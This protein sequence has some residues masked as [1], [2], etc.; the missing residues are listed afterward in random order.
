MTAAEARHSS[1]DRFGV[2]PTGEGRALAITVPVPRWAVARSRV[3]PRE[4]LGCAYFSFST[5]VDW[6]E[7][8]LEVVAR[9]ENLD[10]NFALT[11]K[12]RLRRG[13]DRV[14]RR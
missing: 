9:V 2:T 11:M 10:A 14:R 5:A 4:T 13:R 8:G 12:T 1:R 6:K 7:Q 3:R